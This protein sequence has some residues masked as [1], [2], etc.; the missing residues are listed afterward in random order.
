MAVADKS[1]LILIDHQVD[2]E[3]LLAKSALADVKVVPYNSK[4]HT[5]QEVISLIRV[6]HRENRAPFASIAVANHG[7]AG[8][9]VSWTWA[10]DLNVDLTNAQDAVDTL[11]PINEALI[12]ALEPT[13]MSKA[14]ITFL[15]CR[16]ASIVSEFIPTLEQLYHVD[17]RGSTDDSGND[18]DGG[19]LRIT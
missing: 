15:A 8:G 10:T 7:P 11:A 9:S 12:A 18:K 13:E 17:F 19:K 3:G 6:A 4:T 2:E 16:L 14:H 1:K 5:T